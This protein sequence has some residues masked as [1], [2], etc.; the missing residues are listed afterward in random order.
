MGV[1]LWIGEVAYG[2][3]ICFSILEIAY[4]K[5]DLFERKCSRKENEK[6]YDDVFFINKNIK[7]S[8]TLR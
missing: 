3:K 1:P 5:G 8:C 2:I 7:C 6:I 4:F